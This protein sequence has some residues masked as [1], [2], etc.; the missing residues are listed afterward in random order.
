LL[1]FQ[2]FSIVSHIAPTAWHIST[3]HQSRTHRRVHPGQNDRSM[4][5]PT[6]SSPRATSSMSDEPPVVHERRDTLGELRARTDRP[7]EIVRVRLVGADRDRI[8]G[9]QRVIDEGIAREPD[10]DGLSVVLELPQ[11]IESRMGHQPGRRA[12]VFSGRCPSTH[13]PRDCRCRWCSEPPRRIQKS[14]TIMCQPRMHR[15]RT[16]E[17]SMQQRE[18]R[19]IAGRPDLRIPL[20]LAMVCFL[21]SVQF[22]VGA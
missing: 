6:V 10:V 15:P 2:I 20:F 12:W 8:G 4:R 17:P 22:A 1:F 11:L 9:C 5:I 3:V 16:G 21:V 14:V 19:R 13:H 7:H 18:R